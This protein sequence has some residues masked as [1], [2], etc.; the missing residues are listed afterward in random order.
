MVVRM[1]QIRLAGVAGIVGAALWTIGDV[2]LIG[3]EATAVDYPLIFQRYAALIDIDKATM[4]LPS[5]E[6][7]LAAGALIAN[8]GIIFYLAGSWH[9]YR[10]LLSAGHRWARTVFAL[11]ICGNAWAP[12]GH[13]GY[14]YLG[15]VYKTLPDTPAAAHP[16]LLDLGAQFA[17]VLKIAWYLPIITLGLAVLGLGV[18]IGLGGTAWPRWFALIANPIAVLAIGSAPAV[19]APDPISTWFGGAAFNLGLLVVYVV[20][21]IMLWTDRSRPAARLDGPD[22]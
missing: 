10:G 7:R 11:L 14:Y 1:L 3:A 21:T 18:R 16:A 19:L 22:H 2:L 15:M 20:S 5:S 6:A 12:L 8:V 13:A 9:L 4:M 17:A